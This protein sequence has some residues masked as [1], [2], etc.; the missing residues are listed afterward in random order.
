MHSSEFQTE[1][2]RSSG[3]SRQRLRSSLNSQNHCRFCLSHSFFVVF[4]AQYSLD[5][6]QLL[7][8]KKIA[9]FL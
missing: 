7:K 5:Y 4:A 2:M 1:L 8:K 6:R 3:A 9:I